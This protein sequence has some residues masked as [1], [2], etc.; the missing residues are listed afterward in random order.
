M[1]TNK[2]AQKM[3]SIPHKNYILIKKMNLAFLIIILTTQYQK[4]QN[5]IYDNHKILTFQ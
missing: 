2:K 5:A 3:N 1:I 4:S